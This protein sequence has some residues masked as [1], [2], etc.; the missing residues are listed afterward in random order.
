MILN[1]T[2]RKIYCKQQINNYITEDL[3]VRTINT[4][5]MEYVVLGLIVVCSRSQKVLQL[6]VIVRQHLA[7]GA[8]YRQL[9]PGL[10]VGALAAPVALG[11]ITRRNCQGAKFA[12]LPLSLLILHLYAYSCCCTDKNGHWQ[13][14]RVCSVFEFSIDV[15]H[16]SMSKIERI[17]ICLW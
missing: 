8:G 5:I 17:S 10:C 7:Q 2:I 1:N 16:Q 6:V 12:M 13:R 11:C 9:S 3:D 14:V 4:N 15:I